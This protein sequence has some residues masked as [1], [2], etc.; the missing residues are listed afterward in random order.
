MNRSLNIIKL[1]NIV[2]QARKL[3]SKYSCIQI[4]VIITYSYNNE[5]LKLIAEYKFL[6]YT[7]FQN[8]IK[9]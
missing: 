5:I 8:S 4:K 6:I 2:S 1:V 9:H 7:F 3:M